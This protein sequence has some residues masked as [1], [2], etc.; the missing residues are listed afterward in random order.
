MN[1]RK[2]VACIKTQASGGQYWFIQMLKSDQTRTVNMLAA[3][4]L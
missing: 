2:A 4:Q 1:I 3:Q